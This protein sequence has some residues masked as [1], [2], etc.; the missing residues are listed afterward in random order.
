[1]HGMYMGW[2]GAAA[3]NAW[4]TANNTRVMMAHE[5]GDNAAFANFTGG[6]NFTEWSAWVLERPGRQ[7]SYSCPLLTTAQNSYASLAAGT[8]TSNFTTLGNAFQA[9]PALRN[10][11][12]RLGWEFNGNTF[13]WQVAPANPTMLANYKTGFNLAAAALKAACPTLKIEWCPNISLDYTN[14]TFAAMYPGTTN[15]DYHGLGGY[16]YYLPGGTP[17]W[18]TRFNWQRTTTNGFNDWVAFARSQGKELGH[19]EWGLV[20]T[21]T[22]AGG[23]DDPRWMAAVLAFQ[24]Q[25]GVKYS[26]YFNSD[27]AW[28]ASLDAYPNAKRVYLRRFDRHDAGVPKKSV[29]SGG[30]TP[31]IL[32]QAGAETGNLTEWSNNTNGYDGEWLSGGA[33]AATSTS[34][35]HTGT[36]SFALTC[37]TSAGDSGARLAKT[38][39]GVTAPPLI[40]DAYYSCWYYIPTFVTV[41]VWWNIFQWKHQAPGGGSDPIYTVN[42]GNRTEASVAKMFLQPYKHVSTA[43]NYGGTGEGFQPGAPAGVNLPVAT[44]FHIEARW[45]FQLWDYQN[46][47]TLYNYAAPADGRPYQWTVNNYSGG[48]SPSP[49]TTYVDDCKITDARWGTQ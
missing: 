47:I 31:N 24:R 40:A 27:A 14:E 43:G 25:H 4:E 26:V 48:L 8:Y 21:G 28:D 12:V 22:L 3:I 19:T 35:A 32:W 34:Q 45:K 9:A 44:W 30:A 13:P 29:A 16:N 17:S 10:T 11:I 46:I 49:L 23:G 18:D 5:F 41:D 37:N 33:T 38:Q 2:N 15:I 1:M 39:T 7:F 36:R 6:T 42:I 20:P